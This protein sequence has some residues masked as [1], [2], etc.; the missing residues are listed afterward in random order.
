MSVAAEWGDGRGLVLFIHGLWMNASSWNPWAEEF[1]GNGYDSI[2]YRWP[3]ETTAPD[4]RQILEPV[5]VRDLTEQLTGIIGTLGRPPIAIGQG[6]G[7]LLAQVLVGQGSVSAAISLTPAP[8]GLAVA[9]AAARLARNSPGLAWATTRVRPVTPSLT[10]FGEAVANSVPAPEARHLFDRYAVAARPRPLM[11]SLIRPAVPPRCGDHERRGPLLLI[12][13]G[14]DKMV[15]EASVG[16]LHRRYRRIEPDAVTDYKVF[17][18]RARSLIVDSG[19][20]A[21]G[22][23]CLDWLTANGL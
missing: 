22:Y 10:R 23:Y 18:D 5:R 14:R 20:H 8:S 6:I 12:A 1:D 9:A 19:W 21:V 11:R 2:T 3:G 15:K 13:A 4:H 16:A 7:G 17:P